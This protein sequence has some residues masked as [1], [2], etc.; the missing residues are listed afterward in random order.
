MRLVCWLGMTLTH[1]GHMMCS[2]LWPPDGPPLT[3]GLVPCVHIETMVS[4]F[5]YSTQWW[6]KEMAGVIYP[7]QLLHRLP[8]T[9]GTQSITAPLL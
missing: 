5:V 1:N 9:A 6:R 3:L 8:T 7:V 2:W 4:L